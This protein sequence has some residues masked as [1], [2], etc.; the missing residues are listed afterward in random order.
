MLKAEKHPFSSPEKPCWTLMACDVIDG[1][2]VN[3]CH[4]PDCPPD[5]PGCVQLKLHLEL[6]HW[7]TQEELDT[8]VENHQ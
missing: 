6:Y 7:P 4:V 8:E 3:K 2:Q 1:K 5:L